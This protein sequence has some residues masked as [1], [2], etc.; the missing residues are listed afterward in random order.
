[1]SRVLIPDGIEPEGVEILRAAGLSPDESKADPARLRGVAA[2]IVRSATKVT[3]DLLAAAPDLKCVV[4]A[5]V[6]VDTIDVAA[7]RARGVV[8]MNTPG[9]STN[10]V[11]ELALGMILA[12]LRE[13]PRADA[14]MKAGRWEKKAFEGAEAAGKTLGIVGCGRIGLALARKA[15]G[16]GMK[17]VGCDP[18]T[19]AEAVAA[20]GAEKVTEAEVLRRADVV[21]FHVP[22]LPETKG[23]VNEAYIGRM[24]EG[25]RLVNCARGNVIVEADLLAALDAGR[26]AAAALDVFAAE[27]PKDDVTRRLVAHPRVVATPHIGAATREAQAAIGREAAEAVVAF[28]VRGEARNA[29]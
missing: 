15:V 19:P 10:A 22:S 6:G 12:L 16:I 23:M 8:V 4:R 24:K 3:A 27:P 1:M 7:A 13:I 21:S 11:A 5:G 26:V 28:L 14:S 29:V 17:A 25:V 18:I 9:A 2:M 20:A